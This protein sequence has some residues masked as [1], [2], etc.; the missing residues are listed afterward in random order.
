MK[1]R[2]TH[3]DITFSEG[4]DHLDFADLGDGDCEVFAANSREQVRLYL[5]RE[6]LQ[7]LHHWLSERLAQ[8]AESEA[9]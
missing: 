5:N 8:L 1:R 4:S 2:A 6:D 9:R 7:A 3:H